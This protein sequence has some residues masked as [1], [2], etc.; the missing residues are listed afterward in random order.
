M[1]RN[2]LVSYLYSEIKVPKKVL[3]NL[4]VIKPQSI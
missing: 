4:V 2:R 1:L 3:K